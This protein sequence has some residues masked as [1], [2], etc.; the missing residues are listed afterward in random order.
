MEQKCE[1]CKMEFKT[2]M[3]L[4]SHMANKHHEHEEKTKVECQSTP[5]YGKGNMNASFP[6][7]DSILNE[8]L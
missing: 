6:F 1:I 2:A 4:V 8:F 7:D 3:E 5:K